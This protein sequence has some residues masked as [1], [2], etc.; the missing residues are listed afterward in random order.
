MAENL[1]A[2]IPK[3]TAT[4]SNGSSLQNTLAGINWKLLGVIGA[5]IIGAIMMPDEKEED[6]EDEE[7][8]E[9]EDEEEIEDSEDS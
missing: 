1:P 5:I 9:E 2:V 3:T 6:Y 7:V 8:P 4:S